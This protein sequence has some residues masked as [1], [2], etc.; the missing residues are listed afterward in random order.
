LERGHYNR[1][2]YD[3]ALRV[4]ESAAHADPKLPFVHYYLG[5]TYLKKQDLERARAEFKKELELEPDVAFTYERLGNVEST[6]SA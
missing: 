1:A 4:L 3:D 6:L 5:E 2:E